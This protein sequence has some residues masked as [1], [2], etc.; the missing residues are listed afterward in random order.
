MAFLYRN[1]QRRMGWQFHGRAR[2]VDDPQVRTSVFANAPELE[3]QQDPEQLGKAVLVD[4]DRVIAPDAHGARRPGGDTIRVEIEGEVE[5]LRYIGI[6]TPEV[7]DNAEPFGEEGTAANRSLVA[8]ELV[9]LES[10]VSDRD[11]FD[12]LLH[13]V[14][15]EDGT[16]V[17]EALVREGHAEAVRFRPDTKHHDARLAPAEEEA[18]KERLGIWSLER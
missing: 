1:P 17:N 10:D 11:R 4:I 2:I 7:G 9:C 8:G 18:R 6:D 15:L 5:R 16:L 3:R 12:R 14:W 13:Y